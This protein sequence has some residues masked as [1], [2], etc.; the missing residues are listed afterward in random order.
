[1]RRWP[2]LWELPV[3]SGP[4]RLWVS[5]TLQEEC[6]EPEVSSPLFP[7][8]PGALS[9]QELA[10][11][12]VCCSTF[13]KAADQIRT[14]A[15][16]L[17]TLFPGT[18]LDELAA[19]SRDELLN[20]LSASG[21][22]SASG[23]DSGPPSDEPLSLDNGVDDSAQVSESG[24]APTERQ[25]N[26]SLD[27]PVTAASDDINAISLATD[28]HARSYL[29]MTSISAVLRAIFRL[30]PAAKEHTAQCA[31]AWAAVQSQLHPSSMA[32]F[33][34]RDPALGLL[35]EQRC[36][37]FY[38]DHVHSITPFLDEEDF[39]QKY[40]SG[41]RQDS[42]WLGLLNMVFALGSIASGSDTLHDQYYAQVR[43]F[44]TIDKMGSGNLESLQALCLLGGYYLHYRNSPNV[45]YGILG[46][47][48]RFGIALGLHRESRR[49]PTITDADESQRYWKR[50]EMRRRT[51]WSLFCLDTWASMTQGR[52]TCGRW[53][54]TTMNTPLPTRLYPEDHAATS[55]QASVNFCLICDRIQLRFAQFSRLSPQEALALDGELLT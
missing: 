37:D 43:A 6:R 10:A 36:I 33:T 1:M 9:Y 17:E 13:D 11:D 44:V 32:L 26:E 23:P 48:H 27:Q 51:W 14:Q 28:Q 30:C 21:A 40:S 47:A 16:I 22:R 7:S 25:W 38:F 31:R 18:T 34:A 49:H 54:N 50:V 19:K 42:S 53:D 2:A 29:G 12:H 8:P 55:L 45:A 5:P 15:Q 35:K 39:R 46:A 3:L 52:P 41:I 20:L 4:R 24:E